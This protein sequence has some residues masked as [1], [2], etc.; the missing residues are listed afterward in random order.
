MQARAASGQSKQSMMQVFKSVHGEY[1]IPGLFKG[2]IPRACLGIWQTLF[3]VTG[4]QLVK[5]LLR[6][7]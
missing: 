5:D 1:G 6:G 3:M 4:A 7:S 2:L